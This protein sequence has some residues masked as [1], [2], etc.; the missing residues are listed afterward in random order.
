MYNVGS[1]FESL[2]LCN[3]NMQENKCIF[4]YKP[5]FYEEKMQQDLIQ[6]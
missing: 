3:Q 2:L 6:C 1:F 5:I 4:A